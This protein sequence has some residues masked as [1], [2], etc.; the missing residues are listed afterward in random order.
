MAKLVDEKGFMLEGTNLLLYWPGFNGILCYHVIYRHNRHFEDLTYGPLPYTASGHEAG[1]VP[2]NSTTDEYKF[3]WYW[4]NR[5]R[6]HQKENMFYF[7]KSDRL[8]HTFMTVK[9]FMLRNY[10]HYPETMTLL[11]YLD[12]VTVKPEDGDFFGYFRENFELVYIPYL[13][14]TFETYN[15]TNIDLRT[16]V[17]FKYAEYEVELVRDRE[18]MKK[19]W[20]EKVP[21]KKIVQPAY[22]EF[23]TN[24]FSQ[25]YGI[26]KPYPVEDVMAAG[27]GGGE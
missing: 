26:R 15:N 1:V 2:A 20:T 12:G 25:A 3:N 23:R 9:P 5:R 13:E 14:C 18:E 19:M 8:I 17:N 27:A 22:A 6:G 11:T 4:D 24:A 10:I 16:F 21:V 7:E